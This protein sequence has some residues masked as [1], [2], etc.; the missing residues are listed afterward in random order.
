MESSSRIKNGNGRLPYIEDEVRRLW[1]EYFE[2]LY[3]IDIEEQ[4]AVHMCGF[5]G[6]GRGNHLGGKPIGRSEV[7]VR[8]DKH[9]NGKAAAKD[10]ITGEMI[11]GG[12]DRVVVTGWWI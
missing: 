2:D 9:K 5:D 4:V 3:N 6:I 11:R 7:E 8:V 12:S 10:E 1:K